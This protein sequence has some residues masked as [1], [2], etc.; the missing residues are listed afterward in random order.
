MAESLNNKPLVSVIIPCYNTE[1]YVES[2]VR[3]IMS[4]TYKN[5]E[6]IVT[7]DCSTDNTFSI[8]EKLADEDNR[9]KLFKNETNLKIVKTLNKMVQLANGKY[10]ARMDADD[11]SL[12]ERIEKQVEFLEKNSDIAFCGTNAWHINEN[13]KKIGKSVL[14]INS[15][16]VRKLLPFFSTFYHPTVMFRKSLC[17]TNLY[18]SDFLYVEDYELWCRLI[19]NE[20]LKATNLKDNLLNYRMFSNQTSKLHA[21]EQIKSSMKI[22]DTYPIIEK[23]NLLCHKNIFF[24]HAT[25]CY[26]EKEI[27][28]YYYKLLC[29][30][31]NSDIALNKFVFHIY[32]CYSTTYFF[33]WVLHFRFCSVLVKIICEKLIRRTR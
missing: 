5:L 27:L 23:E 10:I 9:I 33:S 18:S 20:K 13:G 4:Q 28:K 2:A 8:L 29:G 17:S 6:I 11:I 15:D 1:K 26:N 12:P 25:P 14:P 21:K 32:N 7:D 19:F 3:S 24:S 31:K 30:I 22:F 16:D